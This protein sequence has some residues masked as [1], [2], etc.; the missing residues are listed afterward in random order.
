MLCAGHVNWD[1]TLQVDALPEPDGEARITDQRR[2]GGG[3]AANAAVA[4]AGL[5]V[6]VGLLGS[7]GDDEHG[8][9]LREALRE[10]GV[11]LDALRTVPG[12]ETT[13][14]YLVVEPGGEV[15]VLGNEGANE[16]VG[17]DD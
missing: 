3:S 6:P 7:V 11:A 15:F 5:G 4:L 1:V 14:K 9:A 12:A 17:P 10:R 8:A 16:A 13:V 2:S